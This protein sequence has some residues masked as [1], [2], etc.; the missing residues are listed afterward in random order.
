MNTIFEQYNLENVKGVAHIGKISCKEL[1]KEYNSPLYVYNQEIIE[2][3]I[4]ELRNT[5]SK[6]KH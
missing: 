2:K 1:I 4:H 3:R 6:V 5:F